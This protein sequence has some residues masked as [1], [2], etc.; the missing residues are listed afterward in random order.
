MR[1]YIR[2]YVFYKLCYLLVLNVFCNVADTPLN[3]PLVSASVL[4]EEMEHS[5]QKATRMSYFIMEF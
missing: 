5:L 3:F 2:I 4:A 1:E